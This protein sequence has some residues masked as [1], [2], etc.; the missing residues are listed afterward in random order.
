MNEVK[1][2]LARKWRSKN[3]NEIVGQDLPVRMLKNS[4]YREQ[5]FPVYLFSGQRGCGKTTT[6]RVFAMALNCA[7]LKKF[8][9]DPQ[10]IILPCLLCESCVVALSGKHPDFIEID[11]ASHTGVDNVRQIVEAASYLPVLGSKK[12]YLIDE[13]HM[14]SKAAFNALLKILEE[15][16]RS[17]LFILATTDLHKIIDTVQSRCFQLFF[18]PIA[19]SVLFAHLQNVCQA[20][21]I[22]FEDN[23]LALIVEESEGSARDA[24]NLL[25]QVRFSTGLVTK[26]AVLQVLG[27]LDDEQV[28]DLFEAI[29][30][31]WPA[32]VLQMMKNIDFGSHDPEFVWQRLL[33]L[34]R[35]LLWV[36]HGISPI[37]FVEHVQRLNQLSVQCSFL[38]LNTMLEIMYSNENAFQ[39]AAGKNGFF[40]III[41]QMCKKNIPEPDSNNGMSSAQSS[42]SS[43]QDNTVVLEHTE[44]EEH[45]NESTDEEETEEVV[46]IEKNN[47]HSAWELFVKDICTLNDPLVASVVTQGTYLNFDSV[48]GKLDIEFSSEVT[49]FK[50]LL[51]DSYKV[52]SPLIQEKFKQPVHLHPSFTGVPQKKTEHVLLSNKP[53]GGVPMVEHSVSGVSLNSVPQV[54]MSVNKSYEKKQEKVSVPFNKKYTG[55]KLSSMSLQSLVVDTSDTSVWKTAHMIMRHFPGT[56]REIR[57]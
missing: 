39:R 4:L 54:K 34:I 37:V 1:L 24:L 31:K 27:H 14:L 55:S 45:D 10:A 48:S 13:A 9:Q 26:Q 47:F 28:I 50:S 43:M 2:N 44:H 52:W 32:D 11:A 56:V 19:S 25:E 12:I 57:E 22:L 5:F 51:E 8:Q 33:D 36:K 29:I 53:M 23:A 30:L 49:F 21:G 6:A 3:F 20:E 18:S 38:Q 41:L 17:T 40:E 46:E 15:P 16:P 42:V 35:A 7:L